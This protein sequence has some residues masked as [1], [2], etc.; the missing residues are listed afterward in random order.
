MFS[1]FLLPENTQS[2]LQKIKYV[3]IKKKQ[4]FKIG[5]SNV[6]NVRGYLMTLHVVRRHHRP[7][8]RKTWIIRFPPNDHHTVT[9]YPDM[10]RQ[11]G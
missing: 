1:H 2:Y 11:V 8:L 5:Y 9:W 4:Y 3:I 6:Q 7:N 10:Q